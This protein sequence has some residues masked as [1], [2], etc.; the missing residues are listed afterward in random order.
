MLVNNSVVEEVNDLLGIRLNKTNNKIKYIV[1]V[2]LLGTANL[3]S[4]CS[5]GIQEVLG[6]NAE[7]KEESKPFAGLTVYFANC[8]GYMVPISYPVEDASADPLQTAIMLLLEGPRSENLFRTIPKGTRLKDSYVSNETAFLDLTH[9]FNKLSNAKDAERAIKSLCLTV[10]S[11]SGIKE[12][13]IL[14][15]GKPVEE[16]HGVEMGEIMQHS[17]ANC[18]GQVEEGSKY[19]VYFSDPSATYMVPL[20][21]VSETH[22]KIPLKAVEKLIAGPGRE[23]LISTVSP[24]TGL[25]GL[26]IGDGIAYVNL[27]EGIMSSEGGLEQETRFIESLLLTLGQFSDIKGVQILVDGKIKD[28]LPEGTPIAIPLLPLTEPNKIEAIN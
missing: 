18:F 22:E 12:V 20:T 23:Y 9:E 28:Y 3:V 8:G 16:I 26:E 25:L 11:L 17:W 15:E 2:M 5:S 21:Y 7:A 14:V 13:Q 19:I 24:G 6:M 27:S 10:G 4:G 1:L